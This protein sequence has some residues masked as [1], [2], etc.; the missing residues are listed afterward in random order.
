MKGA[1]SQKAIFPFIYPTLFIFYVSIIFIIRNVRLF[2]ENEPIF[3]LS[4]IRK[5]HG[6]WW[7]YY[8]NYTTAKYL[9]IPVPRVSCKLAKYWLIFFLN[10]TKIF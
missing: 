6:F 3:Y 10:I 1:V 7:K 4:N 8:H 5:L 9:Y 2:V